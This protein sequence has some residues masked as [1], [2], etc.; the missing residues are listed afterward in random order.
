MTQK[1]DRSTCLSC[2]AMLDKTWSMQCSKKWKS[3][4]LFGWKSVHVWSTYPSSTVQLFLMHS[5]ILTSQIFL[6]SCCKKVVIY[7]QI[8]RGREKNIQI[9]LHPKCIKMQDMQLSLS[10]SILMTIIMVFSFFFPGSSFKDIQFSI[11]FFSYIA[12]FPGSF[13]FFPL[14]NTGK[15]R[16][17]KKFSEQ[18]NPAPSG[19]RDEWN[20][21]SFPRMS[22]KSGG[23]EGIRTQ[24]TYKGAMHNGSSGI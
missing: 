4:S 16:R 10:H 21:I 1:V 11:L 23:G 13:I 3:G 12:F 7:G 20:A 2:S 9:M 8:I 24:P 22:W 19:W 5:D 18:I 14:E 17:R 15:R 6:L